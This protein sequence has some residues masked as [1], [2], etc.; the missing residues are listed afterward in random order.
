MF[1]IIPNLVRASRCIVKRRARGPKKDHSAS[2]AIYSIGNAVQYSVIRQHV[3]TNVRKREEGKNVNRKLRAVRQIFV[4][5]LRSREI[6]DYQSYDRKGRR[7]IHLV[8]PSHLS[9]VYI[10]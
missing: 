1:Y 2:R 4:L 8:S 3:A 5:L 10:T 7:V 9:S 6:R